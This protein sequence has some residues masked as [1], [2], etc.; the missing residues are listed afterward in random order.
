MVHPIVTLVIFAIYVTFTGL[1]EFIMHHLNPGTTNYTNHTSHFGGAVIGILLG[2]VIL[3]NIRVNK[4]EKIL[5]YACGVSFS[6]WMVTLIVL[7]F[8]YF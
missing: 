3:R 6:I 1:Y 2:V 8:C 7:N 5:Y 4:L